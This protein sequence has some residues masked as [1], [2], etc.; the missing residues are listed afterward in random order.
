MIKEILKEIIS[1]KMNG[2]EDEESAE[3]EEQQEAPR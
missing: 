3:E 2:E 1:N